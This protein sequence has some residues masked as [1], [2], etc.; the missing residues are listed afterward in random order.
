LGLTADQARKLS[1][2]TIAGAAKMLVSSD[3]SPELLRKKVTSPNGTTQAAI[4]HMDS[5]HVGR[6]IEDAIRA[7]ARRSQELG[8]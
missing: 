4:E 6:S 2:R 8:T 5:Q 1:L 7:A 3:D